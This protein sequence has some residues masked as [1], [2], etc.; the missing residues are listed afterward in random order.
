MTELIDA[1]AD[2]PTLEEYLSRPLPGVAGALAAAGGDIVLLGA[3]GKIGPSMARMARRALADTGSDAQVIAVSRFSDAGVRAGLEADG[4]R[5]VAADLAD[6]AAYAGLPDAASV[7]FLAAMKFG[8]TGQEHRTWWSNAAIPTLVA[9]HYRGVP[10]VVY[11]TG[12]VYPLRPVTAG[13][14]VESD[15]VDPVGE[16]AQ[17]C[18]A[19][20]RIFTHAAHEWG[21]PTAVFR[22]NYACELRYGVIADIAVK[23]AAGEPVDVT[24]PAVNVA[25]QGDVNAWALRSLS[26]AGVPPH[27][28]NAT[29]PETVPVRRLALLLAERMGVEP[30]FSGAESP[31]SLLNDASECHERFG[32]PSVPLRRLVGWVAEWVGKGGRQLNKATKFQ[33]REGRF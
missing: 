1:P 8:T 12:N 18:L 16:Y 23:L 25:W 14:A 24:M 10:T 30:T 9:A 32:Y 6:P 17:S 15:P 3:G 26:L 7:Y 20:E 28:L 33:Q 4:V 5:T 2:E 29:G 19:R 21:T 27:V 11:S 31:D 13:G 22:L